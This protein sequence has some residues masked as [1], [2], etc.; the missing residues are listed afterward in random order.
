MAASSPRSWPLGAVRHA[1]PAQS[2]R[3]L[4]P[5]NSFGGR[6]SSSPALLSIVQIQLNAN[7]ANASLHGHKRADYETPRPLASSCGL[8][9]E[10]IAP[11]AVAQRAGDYEL[12]QADVRG[13]REVLIAPAPALA[14]LVSNPGA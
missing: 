11:R 12:V 8:A 13:R 5:E 4:V 9:F 14:Q 1:T 7:G 10:L 6:S 2:E 3:R